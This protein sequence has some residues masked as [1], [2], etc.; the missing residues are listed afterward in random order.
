M[1]FETIQRILGPSANLFLEYRIVYIALSSYLKNNISNIEHP[2][3][4]LLLNGKVMPTSKL[5]RNFIVNL[6]FVEP[7]SSRFWENK[8]NISISKDIWNIPISST[9]ESRLREL[10]WKILHN[11][12]PTNILLTKMGLKHSN[13]CS[14]CDNSID[15]IEHFFYYCSKIKDIWTYVSD[16]FQSFF[17][18][19]ITLN[20][21]HVLIGIADKA[22]LNL[23]QE[24]LV[25]LNHLVL[26]GK[27]CI[28]KYKYG[29]PIN[30]RIMFEKEM[31]LRKCT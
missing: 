3:H 23:N 13:I 29:T 28:S 21:K 31:L 5:I 16:Y 22:E 17:D 2:T 18:I 25:V 10:Q 27:M 11:I 4:Y 6:K 8:L 7:C 24:Q 9:K 30:L 15:F 14:F 26:I 19:R 1:D 20:V 12:Y